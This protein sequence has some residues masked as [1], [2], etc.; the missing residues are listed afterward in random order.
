ME[1]SEMRTALTLHCLSYWLSFDHP[2][3]CSRREIAGW[4]STSST[5]ATRQATFAPRCTASRKPSAREDKALKVISLPA[6]KGESKFVFDN[7]PSGRYAVM[8]YHDENAD[9]KLNLRFGMFPDRR[10]WPLQQPES[11]GAA[12]I[13]R[14]CLR[15]HRAGN[16]HQHQACLLV[17]THG[18]SMTQAPASGKN[19][20]LRSRHWRQI[21][22]QLH[23]RP[24][25]TS[26]RGDGKP[27]P[28]L[29]RRLKKPAANKTPALSGWGFFTFQFWVFFPVDR[30]K[31]VSPLYRD[32]SAIKQV[33]DWAARMTF[34]S[35]PS[36]AVFES[37]A[38]GHSISPV[39]N[40][41]KRLQTVRSA[42]TL[43]QPP[44]QGSR[45]APRRPVWR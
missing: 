43:L 7:L 15:D 32:G 22:H 16:I 11:D 8:V 13:C 36:R 1:K 3:P 34:P 28:G 20:P 9:Q 37:A 42:R 24:D 12:E 31:P 26:Q 2:W 30:S 17:L 23:V 40:P 41:G 18:R 19:T 25:A 27:D 21:R 39:F 45:R 33:G 14:Q 38:S 10:L 5:F 4:S 35:N 6:A 29:A 44:Q